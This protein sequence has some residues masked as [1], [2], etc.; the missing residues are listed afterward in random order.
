MSEEED[1]GGEKGRGKAWLVAGIALAFCLILCGIWAIAFFH[2]K[3]AIDREC[4]QTYSQA[5][6]SYRSF[7]GERDA[8]QNALDTSSAKSSPAY[9]ALQKALA[10]KTDSAPV[11]C[12]AGKNGSIEGNRA[13]M[14]TLSSKQ[15]SLSSLAANLLESEK[16]AN[17]SEEKA[18]AGQEIASAKAA[19]PALSH[20]SQSEVKSRIS[21]LEG[22]VNSPSP[23]LAG[24]KDAMLAL[25]GSLKEAAGGN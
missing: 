10:A 18:L 16:A 17:I 22:E 15:A 7:E 25:E 5:Q 21:D 23:S 14:K 13:L 1:A 12:S 3:K 19:L 8:A 20:S 2:G 6:E 24:V 11:L 9:E 4:A